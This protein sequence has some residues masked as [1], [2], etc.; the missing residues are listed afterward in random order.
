[1]LKTMSDSARAMDARV[2][3]AASVRGLLES[4]NGALERSADLSDATGVHSVQV[5]PLGPRIV[6]EFA[7]AWLVVHGGKHDA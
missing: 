2:M 5:Y 4:A 1:M 3:T 6:R 7:M